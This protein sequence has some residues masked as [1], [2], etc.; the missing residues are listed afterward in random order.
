[1]SSPSK[2]VTSGWASYVTILLLTLG[3]LHVLFGLG[4]LDQKEYFAEDGLIYSNLKL[5]GWL[6]IGLGVLQL[7]AA[8]LV[9][10]RHEMGAI[11]AVFL[12]FFGVIGN[13]LAIGAYPVWSIILLVANA[14]VIWA[15]CVHGEAFVDDGH[16]SRTYAD[17]SR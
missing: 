8:Y 7:L 12:A 11:I 14:L 6:A 5:W 4:A 10:A 3:V 9:A 15:V 2:P 16:R 17:E 13:F 1:M